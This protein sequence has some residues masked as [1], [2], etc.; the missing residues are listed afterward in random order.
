[1][2]GGPVVATTTVTVTPG[3]AVRLA[4]APRGA[5]VVAGDRVTYTAVATDAFGNAWD[6]TAE[7]TWAAGGGN[8]FVGNVLSATVAGTWPVTGTLGA[9][10]DAT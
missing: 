1:G 5:V 10:T 6:A 2:A 9:A 8:S 3:P 7:T 4:I